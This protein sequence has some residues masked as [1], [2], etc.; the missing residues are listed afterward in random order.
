M[1]TL[2]T[3]PI[4]PVSLRD[5]RDVDPYPAYE[6]MRAIGSVIWDEGMRAWL[7]LSHDGCTFVERNE[8]LFEEPTG[9]LP[10]AADIVGIRD[11]RSLVG[12]QHE[13]LHRALSHAW[14][15]DP[16]APMA[17]AAVRPLVTERLE[18]LSD[19]GGF[20]LF[21]DFARLL[22]IA[23]IARVLG[24]PD[25][26]AETLDRA[27][28]WM[29]AVLAWRHSY[30]EDPDARVAAVEAT[31]LLEPALL[32]TVRE[33]RDRPQDDAISFLWAQGREVADDW[34][35]QDV[36]DNAKFLFEGGS[37]TTAFLVCNAIHRLVDLPD[38]ERAGIVSDSELLGRFVEEILRHETV[39]HLRARRATTDV[40]LDGVPI[41]SGERVI[42]INAAANR[43][44][45][46]WERPDVFD[47]ARPR[48]YGHLAFNVGPRHCVG[49]HLARMEAIESIGA[50]WRAFP[51]VALAAN[52]PESRM[53]GFVSRARRPIHLAH[54]PVPAAE[55]RD[56]I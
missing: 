3:R 30:G 28:G 33:R 13:V 55:V 34:S 54:A 20:E 46:R 40:E 38:Q 45:A 35:E 36:L 24:L 4:A 29:E 32:D 41:R 8:D 25:A 22:P 12:S 27:K 44:P 48:L 42:A 15:P 53:I 37:E 19:Q 16:I 52:A 5:L 39:V 11:F 6:Q 9:S 26:D 14:R 43:D 21:A 17:V 47:P 1:T 7:V 49:A 31:R 51:D 2:L 10:G 23:V 50:M 56:R 18:G